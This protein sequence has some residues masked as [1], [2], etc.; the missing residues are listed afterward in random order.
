MV[1]NRQAPDGIPARSAAHTLW[2]PKPTL[3]IATAI[4]LAY[5]AFVGW[6]AWND[7]KATV[8]QELG[9]ITELESRAL[10][11][12][13]SHLELGL[14]HLGADLT[15]DGDQI[16]LN[17]AY[18]AVKRFHEI[19]PELINVSLIA[20]DGKL[21]LTAKSP[22]GSTHATLANE[23]SFT[24]YVSALKQGTA[25]ALGRPLL[26]V[27]TK[28]AIVPLRHPLRDKEGNLRYVLSANL[29]HEHLRSFW[30]DAPITEKAA[31]GL[32]R[33]NGYLLSRYPVPAAA[34]LDEIYGKPRT[35]VLIAH[36]QERGFPQA[37]TVQ[38]PSSLD[39]PDYLTAFRRL[40]NHPVTLFVT[41]PMS[42]VR[43]SWWQRVRATYLALLVLVLGG[44]FAYAYLKRRQAQ[45]ER[46]EEKILAAQRASEG[47][48]RAVIEAS[49]IPTAINDKLQ[50]VTYLNP[51]FVASFGY[52]LDDIP[53]LEQWWPK[54]YPDPDYRD[55]VARTWQAHLEASLRNAQAFEPLEIRVTTKSGGQ[56]TVIAAAT[57]L[58]P[59]DTGE[60]VV[61]LYDITDRKNAEEALLDSRQQLLEAQ[62]IAQ[63]G[64]WHVI[65]GRGDRPDAWTISDELRRMYG[66]AN[67]V[68]I[69]KE[70]GFV[71]MP[72][73]D[74]E[75]V[76]KIWESARHGKGP[77][78][79][80]HRI[81]VGDAVK[82]MQVSARFKFDAD[83]QAIEASGT[84]HDVTE[85]KLAEA[86]LEGHRHHLEELVAARTA[87]L[88]QA[89]DDAQA[90]N[91][92]KSV[93]LANMSHELRTPMN[94][95]MGMTE[96]LLRRVTDPTQLDWLRK[97]QSA[98]QHL[99]SVINN[100]LDISKIEAD[101]MT[102]NA[103]DFSPAQA[104]EDAIQMQIAAAHA[105]GLQLS[106]DRSSPLPDRAHGDTTRFKQILLNFIGNAIKFSG[107]GEITVR[108]TVVEQDH[109][110]LL[111][112]L[113]VSDQGIG[114]TPEQQARLFHAF[115][116]ADDT[117]TRRYGGTG[118]GLI[119]SKRIA[120]LMGGEVGASSEPGKGSCFWATV[121]LKTAMG[122]EP[123][124]MEVPTDRARQT[125]ERQH[126]GARIL[127]AEDEPVNREVITSILQDAGLALDVVT[128]GREALEKVR[129][130]SYELILLDIQMPVMN[131]LEAARA[132]R[133]LPGMAD[134]PILALTA[135]AFTEDRDE[136]LAAGMNQHIGKPVEPEA[137]YK[138]VLHWLQAARGKGSR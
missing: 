87:E 104:I 111:I 132:I 108:A 106:H 43:T 47:R 32:I 115:T 33:D 48:F 79:W 86:E 129:Q 123:Q 67:G 73:E 39:G 35:G 118:L 13:F 92:A 107:Q 75:R 29:S 95:I 114:I 125:L 15:R 90:A 133:G 124:V 94:G 3:A 100:I 7:E 84:N 122:R 102:L 56:R 21:L 30:M 93:F 18:P 38:G 4:V 131:G 52:T 109:Q 60:S 113:E 76:A 45:W 44:A 66:H 96:L 14:R 74:R 62:S 8:E 81:V 130:E 80:E 138:T 20:A 40:T 61:T 31:I 59:L 37:G 82:W 99:L 88:A 85:R 5:A 51:A 98:A 6:T 69:D 55:H 120:A 137:L 50:K 68:Q 17:K 89:R 136:C 105:K 116:Q 12:Y 26:G 71:R 11:S 57:L 97:S 23:S 103:E 1:T 28:K 134:I 110:G 54:A 10:D 42:D 119:I 135:N 49:T 53:T 27:V 101:R 78:S 19:S 77:D 2:L 25:V 41:L 63:L 24:E 22:P 70:T 34:T 121:R 83:G 64:S 91:R 126:T 36:L 127:I 117:A 9:T 16:D 65:F 58:E 112:R 46:A 72:P 128:N